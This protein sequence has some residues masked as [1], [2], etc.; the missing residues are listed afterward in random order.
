VV[1]LAW[2]TAIRSTTSP[3]R[4]PAGHR[5]ADLTDERRVL[6]TNMPR[7]IPLAHQQLPQADVLLHRP[8]KDG[9]TAEAL[10]SGGSW[11]VGRGTRGVT[12]APLYLEKAWLFLGGGGGGGGRGGGLVFFMEYQH[13][14][15]VIE[16]QGTAKP[17]TAKLLATLRVAVVCAGI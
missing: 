8:G 16:L 10:C 1:L 2:Q 14:P 12:D 9:S 6:P 13:L 4:E 3:G 15:R 7:G 17:T 11:Q 5:L